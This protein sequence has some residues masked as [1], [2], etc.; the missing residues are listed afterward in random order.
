MV[1]NSQAEAEPSAKDIGCWVSAERTHMA[2]EGPDRPEFNFKYMDIILLGEGS[3]DV[4]S[5]W[6]FAD[7]GPSLGLMTA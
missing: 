4:D 6:D 5:A 2:E 3:L 1:P 7:K